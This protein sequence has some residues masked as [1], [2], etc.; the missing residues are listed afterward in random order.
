[1]PTGSVIQTVSGSFNTQGNTNSVNPVQ[2]WTGLTITPHFSDS[3]IRIEANTYCVHRDYYD[4]YLQ[5]Y[6]NGSAVTELKTI[7]R[8]SGHVGETFTSAS[9]VGLWNCPS[10]PMSFTQSAGG[11]SA[12]TYSVYVWTQNTSQ[13]IYYNTSANNSFQPTSTMTLT[14]IAA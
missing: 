7:V 4:G 9:T 8:I 2:I 3:T 13:P 6:K 12:L 14:E 5:I 11:T 10:W 1:M